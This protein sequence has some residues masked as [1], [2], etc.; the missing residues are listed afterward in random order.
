M[1]IWACF[2]KFLCMFICTYTFV[3]PWTKYLCCVW[4]LKKQFTSE[5]HDRDFFFSLGLG[6]FPK[7]KR[8]SFAF[9]F[10]G[11]LYRLRNYIFVFWLSH[12]S[13]V[14]AR[15]EV[16]LLQVNCY[17]KVSAGICRF[18]GVQNLM[19]VLFPCFT[20]KWFDHL[21]SMVILHVNVHT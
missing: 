10:Y 17:N 1:L 13:Q 19:K 20:P 4:F 2:V 9:K 3:S 7:N 8:F 18:I 5:R 6:F 11:N 12:I 14:R 21:C 16:L 15:K